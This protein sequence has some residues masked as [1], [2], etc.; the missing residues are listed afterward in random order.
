LVSHGQVEGNETRAQRSISASRYAK[1]IEPNTASSIRAPAEILR[2]RRRAGDGKGG[3]RVS[4]LTAGAGRVERAAASCE[5][6]ACE[7]SRMIDVAGTGV[8]M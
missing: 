5:V 7:D 4:F 3:N 8:A 2:F 6:F 1:P